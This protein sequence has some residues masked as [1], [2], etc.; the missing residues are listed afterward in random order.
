MTATTAAMKATASDVHDPPGPRD[1]RDSLSGLAFPGMTK[2]LVIQTEDLEPQAAAW[3]A[4]RCEFIQI[5]VDKLAAATDTLAR[6]AGLVVRTYTKVNRELLAR[7]PRLR[8]VARAGVGLD[9]IDLDACRA[10]GIRVVH[11]PDANGDAV[12]ELVFALIFDTIRPRLFL[13]KALDL[14]AWNRLRRELTAPRQLNELTIG[15][16]GLGKIGKRI[17]RLGSTFGATVLYHDLLDITPDLR[18]GA[19]PVSREQVMA[20]SDIV[21]VHID[22]RPENRHLFDAAAF[23]R[24]KDDVIFLNTSRGFVVDHDALAGFLKAHPAARAILDVH[25]PE[26][27]Q[28]DCPL[29]GLPNAHLTPHIASATT[30]AHANMSWVVKDVWRVLSGEPP[31]YVAV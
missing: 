26:P 10:R 29:L 24:L 2:P 31:L 23:A 7:A 30:R 6:A 27:F 18:N 9:N 12:A 11:T 22:N 19:A 1:P 17:A 16:Y 15:V 5:P 13:E 4:E 25:D 20:Q 3:L 8:V 14:D 21:T 28:P